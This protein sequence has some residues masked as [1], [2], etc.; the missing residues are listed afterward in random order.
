[1]QALE[2]EPDFTLTT[3][4]AFNSLY[5]DAISAQSVRFAQPI[6]RGGDENDQ[7]GAGRVL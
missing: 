4:I 7:A 1:M 2:A 3:R 5:G 6:G